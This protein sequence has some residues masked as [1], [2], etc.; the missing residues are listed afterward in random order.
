MPKIPLQKQTVNLPAA[1]VGNLGQALEAVE[2]REEL[3]QAMRKERR[4]KIKEAN[5]LKGM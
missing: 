5:Y 1:E 2:K 3:R 4:A